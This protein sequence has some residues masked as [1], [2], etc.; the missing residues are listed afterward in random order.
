MHAPP[1]DFSRGGG[2]V[3]GHGGQL[4]TSD[5]VTLGMEHIAGTLG[6]PAWPVA[7]G[8]LS[9]GSALQASAPGGQTDVG[10]ILG[11]LI[12]TIVSE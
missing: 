6:I 8:E 5:K 1:L 7:L 4:T 12:E 3:T 2:G 10:G 9:P 11:L